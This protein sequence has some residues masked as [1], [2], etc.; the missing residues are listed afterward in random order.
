MPD[1][2]RVLSIADDRLLIVWDVNTGHQIKKFELPANATSIE[3]SDDGQL[4]TITY[5]KKVT[6][7]DAN[8]FEKVK[9]FTMAN[10]VYSA[11]LHKE[12]KDFVSGGIDFVVYKHDFETGKEIGKR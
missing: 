7:W 4:L 11:S 12:R 3:V 9:E 10:E 8:K 5:G 1:D 6:F 2:R